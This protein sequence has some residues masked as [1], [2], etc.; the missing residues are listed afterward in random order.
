MKATIAICTYNRGEDLEEAINSCLT[1]DFDPK[2]YEIIVVDNRSTDNTKEIVS[3]YMD[4]FEP[5]IHY[6][7]EDNLGLSYA[8]NR[9]IKEA[10]GEY[11]LF[12]D[13]DAIA[14]KTWIKKIIEVFEN[15]EK[16]GCVGGKIEPI[17]K[18]EVPYWLPEKYRTIYSILDY[19][20]E[21]TEMGSNSIPFGANVSFRAKIFRMI[22]PFRVDLGRI[23]SSLLSGEESELIS[24]IRQ[25]YKVYY[26][27]L[28]SV[29]HKIAK[30]R[31][32]M[33]WFLRR[34]YWQGVTDAVRSEQKPKFFFKSNAKIVIA[35]FAL[36]FSFYNVKVRI[37]LLINVLHSS[38]VVVGVLGSHKSV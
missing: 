25:K 27:P 18:G 15:D 9:A 10:K 28:A 7:H 32:T 13:D 5:Q 14:S 37:R 38:G 4:I 31:S 29:E 24:R 17:W 11:I 21:L 34:I 2:D 36:I 33:K 3:G 23:G 16:I 6:F 22:A 26:S 20:D 8:R 30:D 35:A 19:S 1:Q 12:I